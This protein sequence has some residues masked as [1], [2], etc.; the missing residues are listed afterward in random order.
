VLHLL[1][2]EEIEALLLDVPALVSRLEDHDPD[3]VADLKSWLAK[4]EDTF[5]KNRMPA[6]SAVAV[7]RGELIAVERGD[8]DDPLVKGRMGLRKHREAKAAHLLRRAAD[9]VNE[10]IRSRRSQVDEASRWMMQLVA[11]ASLMG[12]IPPDTTGNHTAYLRGILQVVSARAELNSLVV[13][14]MGLLGQADCLI[15]LDRSITAVQAN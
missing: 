8:V 1:N 9:I 4:V 15:V 10:T 6:A 14:V 12:L 13:H 11:A 2:L 5:S 3:F 7:C